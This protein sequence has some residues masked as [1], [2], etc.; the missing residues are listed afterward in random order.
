MIARKLV[1]LGFLV[2]GLFGLSMIPQPASAHVTLT[3]QQQCE[4]TYQSCV[5]FCHGNQECELGCQNNVER[6][7][8]E[9][10]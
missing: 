3:C 10:D 1:V 2:G 9:C 4:A 6:C 8:A 7:L 5:N